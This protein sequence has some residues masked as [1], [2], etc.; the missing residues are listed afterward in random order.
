METPYF[1]IVDIYDG[2]LSI[3]CSYAKRVKF[4]KEEMYKL[5]LDYSNAQM[6]DKE[7]FKKFCP[8]NREKYNI[9]SDYKKEL[10]EYIQTIPKMYVFEGMINEFQNDLL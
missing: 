9:N 1:T 6:H 4:C 3:R 8:L 5:K 7:Y 2:L 10:S